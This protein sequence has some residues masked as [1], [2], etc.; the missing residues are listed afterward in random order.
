MRFVTFLASA[1]VLGGVAGSPLLLDLETLL[2]INLSEA[3]YYGAPIPPWNS[4]AHPGW[5]S[6]AHPDLFP[7]L[8]CLSGLVCDIL[9]LLPKCLQ[10]PQKPLPPLSDGYRQIFSN[11]TGATQARDYLTFGL[12]DTIDLCK[13]MCNSV[14]G[15][16]F[17]NT[18]HDVN[19]K[20]G[21]TQ[22]SCSLFSQCHNSSDAT[23]L[24]G[25]TQ[26]NGSVDFI[27]NS[28]GWCNGTST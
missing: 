12:V 26:P 5:Y 22:L 8:T 16:K 7:A 6:G 17:V 28:D 27:T 21:S 3:N 4:D 2:G 25:Q 10:C 1:V 23:N 9:K 11:L 13:A 14:S 20:G 19:G 24:G 18:Y 15:C